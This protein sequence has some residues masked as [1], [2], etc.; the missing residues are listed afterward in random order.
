MRTYLEG[1]LS[2][3]GENCAEIAGRKLRA[4]VLY[5]TPTKR[6][7]QTTPSPSKVVTRRIIQLRME[8]ERSVQSLA[9]R[10]AEEDADWLTRDV[11]ANLIYDRRQNV[12]IDE[13]FILARV[14]SMFLPE[15]SWSPRMKT[16]RCKLLRTISV[17]R[18]PCARG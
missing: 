9:D 4:Q 14:S 15:I 12:P 18:E 3:P 16:P 10:C 5:D 6:K 17:Q 13:V 8:R 2:T 1:E 7:I 11:L